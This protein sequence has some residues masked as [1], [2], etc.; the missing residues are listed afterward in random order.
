MVTFAFGLA[1]LASLGF[2]LFYLVVGLAE[3]WGSLRSDESRQQ[4]GLAVGLLHLGAALALACAPFAAGRWAEASTGWVDEDND[5]MLDPFVNGGYDYLDVNGGH[6]IR[7]WGLVA[8]VVIVATSVL[9][10]A[11]RAKERVSGGAEA[12]GRDPV[13]DWSG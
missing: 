8:L 11:L 2:L 10:K 5:G 6:L 3:L 4:S 1:V 12:I 13:G 9:V 7:A